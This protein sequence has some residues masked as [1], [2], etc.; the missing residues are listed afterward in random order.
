MNNFTK[1]DITAI[2]V[3]V[4][5]LLASDEKFL[6][7]LLPELV[8]RKAFKK[9][10]LQYVKD[11]CNAPITECPDKEKHKGVKN[12]SKD[13]PLCGKPLRVNCNGT[14]ARYF[15]GCSGFPD[16][17]YTRNF[18]PEDEKIIGIT[19]HVRERYRLLAESEE[20]SNSDSFSDSNSEVVGVADGK[21][22]RQN[23]VTGAYNDIPF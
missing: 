5:N 2:S 15:I 18:T 6:N 14:V 7:R 9:L 13:C 10:F 19:D 17:K 16:C 3:K 20:L 11:F 23:N 22:I 21:E 12:N 8:R 4:A 1:Q